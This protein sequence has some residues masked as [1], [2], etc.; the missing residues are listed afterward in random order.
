M[1][2]VTFN[3]V[4][5]TLGTI[6]IVNAQNEYIDA[7]KHGIDLSRERAPNFVDHP[8][9]PPSDCFWF[10]YKNYVR[11]NAGVCQSDWSFD[12]KIGQ[13]W[14]TIHTDEGCRLSGIIPAGWLILGMKRPGF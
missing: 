9:I 13:Y 11:Q 3:T 2:F 6:S 7:K 8:G 1:R 12:M 4:F 10:L 14:V 5:L